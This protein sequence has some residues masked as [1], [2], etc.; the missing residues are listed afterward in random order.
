MAL[1]ACLFL[2]SVAGAKADPPW[3]PVPEASNWGNRFE[4]NL[5]RIGVW[6][7]KQGR[8]KSAIP[9]LNI[10]GRIRSQLIWERGDGTR[11]QYKNWT[12][13]QK[14]RFHALFRKLWNGERD[15]GLSCPN[16]SARMSLRPHLT[17]IYLSE[18]EAFDIYAAHAAHALYLEIRGLVPWSI[19]GLPL[20]ELR[21]FFASYNYQSTIPAG[22]SHLPPGIEPG[23][24]FQLPHRHIVGDGLNCDPREGYRFASGERSTSG[25][26]LLGATDEDTLVNLS[27]WLNENVN[28]GGSEDHTKEAIQSYSYLH[29]RLK[30]RAHHPRWKSAVAAAGCHSAA[31]LMHDLAR[32]VNIPLLVTTTYEVAPNDPPLF[33][34]KGP[35][36]RGLAFRFGRSD[37]RVLW[38]SD[39]LYANSLAEFFPIH[40]DGEGYPSATTLAQKKRLFYEL[41]WVKP[42]ELVS[43]GYGLRG[44]VP[45]IAPKFPEVDLNLGTWHRLGEM[46]AYDWEKRYQL[47]SYTGFLSGAGDYVRLYLEED[48]RNLGPLRLLHTVDE[49]VYR[50]LNC[51]GPHGG[52]GAVGEKAAAWAAS[53]GHTVGY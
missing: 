21:A 15:L 32:S 46:K 48:I 14:S 23:R 26:N 19:L 9:F 40:F 35:C 16:P 44:T 25:A 7:A 4:L 42:S 33:G 5:C 17:Q 29:D 47:C 13:A 20:T 6:Y 28:H 39:D 8:T 10:C 51:L 2:I 37:A 38:H 1:S 43:W 24:D 52:F 11:V 49:F 36:H 45:A 12:P 22:T 53:R 41:N 27:Y 30:P 34:C 50:S 3:R 18:R 31:D